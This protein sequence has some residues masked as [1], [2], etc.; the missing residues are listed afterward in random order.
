MR[1]AV[2]GISKNEEHHI[3]RWE[4]CSRDADFRIILDTGSSDKTVELAKSLGV[5]VQERVF[6][7]FSFCAA[8][9]AALAMIPADIDLCITLDMDE[10]LHPGWKE[11]L[12][13]LPANTTRPRYKYIWSRNNDGSEGMVYSGHSSHHR[14]NYEWRHPIHEIITCTGIEVQNWCDMIIEHQPDSAKPRTQYLPM[15]KQH[16]TND[17][18]SDRAAFYY[19]RELFFHNQLAD[20]AAE[21]KRHLRLASATWEP[22][23]SSSMR[24]LAKCEPNN[25]ETWLLRAAAEAPRFRENWVDLAQHYYARQDWL[26]CYH[27]AARAL[28]IANKPMD[29][30][31]EAYAWNETPHDLLALSAYN[32]GLYDLALEHGNVAAN[33]N[34]HDSRLADNLEWY[35]RA[36]RLHSAT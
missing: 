21:F 10:V 23:R 19:A 12:Q 7:P 16:A 28:L 11:A 15:L 34:P 27:A 30:F 31:C 22:E 32:I 8:R 35:K 33:K 4:A 20:A 25:A 14:H 18:E 9:N 36:G 1:V 17:P 13:E 24:Y 5:N 6:E 29:Y 3:K 2:Y 26:G